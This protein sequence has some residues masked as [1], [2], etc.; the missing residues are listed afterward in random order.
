M[1][2]LGTN[3]AASY[4]TQQAEHLRPDIPFEYIQMLS[5]SLSCGLGIQQTPTPVKTVQVTGLK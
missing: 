5:F 1:E 3:D 2:V 4:R